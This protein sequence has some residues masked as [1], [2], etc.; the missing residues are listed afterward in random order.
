[1]VVCQQKALV[2]TLCSIVDRFHFEIA[3]TEV[4]AAEHVR[5]LALSAASSSP[6]PS[7]SSSTQPPQQ[8]SHLVIISTSTAL[9]SS[10]SSST[11]IVGASH[12]AAR[13][14]QQ[15][16]QRNGVRLAAAALID[17]AEATVNKQ[18]Q[19]RQ[20]ARERVAQVCSSWLVGWLLVL[21]SNARV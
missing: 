7:A 9:A 6:S 18:V 12:W 8:Q 4:E 17:P 5:L 11:S 21:I 19:I 2:R 10:S 16:Q 20:R 13:Q 3:A 14:Q 15:Q 1:L